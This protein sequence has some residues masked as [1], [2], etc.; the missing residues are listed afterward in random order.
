MSNSLS[1]SVSATRRFL[2][3][4]MSILAS[5]TVLAHIS[6]VL[7]FS[8]HTF[9]W[10]LTLI[11]VTLTLVFLSSSFR[12]LE[13]ERVSEAT[14]PLVGLAG[15]I[16]TG[17]L[18]GLLSYRPDLDDFYY[19]PNAVYYLQHPGSVMD[20]KIHFI[21]SENPITSYAWGTSLP[22][23]YGRATFSYITGIDFISVYYFL[24]SFAVG[25]I[26]P[27]SHFYLLSKF[28]DQTSKAVFGVFAAMSLLLFMGDT[29]R[30]PG[31]FSF[32]RAFQGKT[33]L[34]SAG[35]PV[36]AAG[37][38]EFF[39]KRSV[40]TWI[41][42]F[43]TATA[44]IGTTASAAALLPALGTVLALAFLL[45]AD[46]YWSVLKAW[47]PYGGSFL[48]VVLYA[49]LV[50]VY[51]PH[52]LGMESPVNEGW[53][54]SF[55]GHLSFLVRP[56]QPVTPFLLLTGTIVSV[57]YYRT[58]RLYIFLLWSILSITI[59]FNPIVSD[60]HIEY[61]TSPNA[62]WRL[63]YTYPIVPS[64]GA[65]GFLCFDYLKSKTKEFQVSVVSVILVAMGVAHIPWFSSSALQHN[66]QAPPLEYPIPGKYKTAKRITNTVPEGPMLAP[67][68]VAGTAVMINSDYP[69]MRVRS[70]GVRLWLGEQKA[71]TRIEASNYVAG[72]NRSGGSF[73]A[74]QRIMRKNSTCSVVI[75]DSLANSN[76]VRSVLSREGYDGHRNVGA[77]EAYWR[78]PGR[79]KACE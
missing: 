33:L 65:I 77:Y 41:L 56:I 7:G 20:F 24:T 37:T 70:D 48:Y 58:H 52:D 59:F 19:A 15:L 54:T 25:T 30:T 26:I 14:T 18:L 62:F 22:Y 46:D 9:S 32:V 50:L 16:V 45:K 35:I 63:L 11:A 69:Q 21:H 72:E 73:S 3:C 64:L 28:T 44:M 61:L 71:Q 42:L 76:Q 53:P 38:I 74:F 1:A 5:C 68:S 17:A 57:I 31:N 8:F 36:F 75:S 4:T 6:Q 79:H 29:H 43:S 10:A 60:F 34:L 23:E 51:S 66:L 2:I 78:P 27:V 55:W 49:V 12:D 39:R 13:V 67:G 47:L 40:R